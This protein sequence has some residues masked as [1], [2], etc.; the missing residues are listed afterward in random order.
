MN[1]FILGSIIMSILFL[2]ISLVFFILKEKSCILISGYNFKTKSERLNYDEVKLS[3]AYGKTCLKYSLIFLFG[4]LG[5]ILFGN[6]FFGVTLCIF[7][8]YFFKDFKL[9]DTIF[10][11]YKK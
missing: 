6:M 1:R 8:I 3:N 11:K 9:D 5:C 2:I 10:D 4:S 7:L